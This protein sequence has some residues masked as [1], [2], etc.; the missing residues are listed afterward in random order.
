[1]EL[2]WGRSEGHRKVALVAWDRVCVP[3]KYGGLNIK[4]CKLW[5][6]G[7]VGK[8][9]R[10]LA[11]KKEVLWVNWIHVVYMK[12]TNNIWEHIPPQDCSW[13]LKIYFDTK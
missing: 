13:Y 12:D 1:M 3:K 11:S 8:L 4:S 6:I 10:Q 2:L 5:N 7:V 9:L